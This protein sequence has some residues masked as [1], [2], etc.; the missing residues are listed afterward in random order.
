MEV[1]R[2]CVFESPGTLLIIF[3]NL[4]CLCSVHQNLDF[5]ADKNSNYFLA[6]RV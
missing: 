4:V 3:E 1:S 5:V 2:S 6:A